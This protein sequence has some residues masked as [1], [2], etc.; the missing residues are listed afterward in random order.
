MT[1]YAIGSLSKTAEN[2]AR[3]AKASSVRYRMA[4]AVAALPGSPDPQ[5]ELLALA[6]AGDEH[7]VWRADEMFVN[8]RR[9]RRK[10]VA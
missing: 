5:H 9:G 8:W 7:A 1:T 3:A 10:A 4:R 2:A 6:R